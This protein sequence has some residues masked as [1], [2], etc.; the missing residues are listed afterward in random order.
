MDSISPTDDD[1]DRAL[2][3]HLANVSAYLDICHHLENSLSMFS[4]LA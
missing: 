4:V 1:V 3:V 2:L